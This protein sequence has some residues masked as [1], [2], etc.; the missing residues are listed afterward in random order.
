MITQNW[1]S[2]NGFSQCHSLGDHFNF[3]HIERGSIS[4]M[5][6]ESYEHWPNEHLQWYI[7]V[8]HFVM[9][10]DEI[11]S[12]HFDQKVW[13]SYVWTFS[14]ICL[15]SFKVFHYS[16]LI[17]FQINVCCLFCNRT[18]WPFLRK[19]SDFTRYYPVGISLWLSLLDLFKI[20][21]F[22]AFVIK[23][24]C[25]LIL[26]D[27]LCKT[28][29]WWIS[30]CLSFVKTTGPLLILSKVCL[31]YVAKLLLWCIITCTYSITEFVSINKDII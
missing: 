31:G 24:R 1:F 20:I 23:G 22:I 14:L 30:Y 2:V 7:T 29:W 6:H 17:S 18:V 21:F 3:F 9:V 10:R 25:F 16:G 4:C 28:E 8:Y 15:H 5:L 27:V 13:L 11:N 26:N 12:D 19:C